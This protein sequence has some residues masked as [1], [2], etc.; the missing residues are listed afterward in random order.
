[1]GIQLDPSFKPH[2]N[3]YDGIVF[4]LVCQGERGAGGKCLAVA[5]TTPLVER[6]CP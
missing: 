2:S 3:Y 5:V 1:V 6:L 4:K